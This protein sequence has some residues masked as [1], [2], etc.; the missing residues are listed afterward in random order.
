[1]SEWFAINFFFFFSFAFEPMNLWTLINLITPFSMPFIY[2]T[3][4]NTNACCQLIDWISERAIRLRKFDI[5]WTDAFQHQTTS[6][7]K[8]VFFSPNIFQ[9]WSHFVDS[10][11]N[12]LI[13]FA[14]S[15][16]YSR[17]GRFTGRFIRHRVRKC[18]FNGCGVLH[19]QF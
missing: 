14:H 16:C 4:T 15:L 17:F 18:M 13:T 7:P 8:M 9:M 2:D 6:I 10:M 19:L 12:S 5:C 1:M 11:K 3:H